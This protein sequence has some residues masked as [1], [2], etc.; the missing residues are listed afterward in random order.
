MHAFFIRHRILALSLAALHKRSSI[1]LLTQLMLGHQLLQKSAQCNTFFGSGTRLLAAK[2][3]HTSNRLAKRA[4]AV[5]ASA[6]EYKYVVLGGGNAAGYAAAEF[7]KRG[8]AKGDV[9]IISEEPV[10]P[11]YWEFEM[12]QMKFIAMLRFR[13][14]CYYTIPFIAQWQVFGEYSVSATQT[15]YHYFFLEK[16]HQSQKLAFHPNVVRVPSKWIC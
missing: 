4:I 1:R 16:Y 5:M 10:S 2:P 13:P 3:I 15:L 6:S 9:A 8:S 14:L 11:K 7:Q 12:L